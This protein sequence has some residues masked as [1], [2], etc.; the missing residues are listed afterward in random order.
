MPCDKSLSGS[1]ISSLSGRFIGTGILI[2]ESP[3]Q[4]FKLTGIRNH[5]AVCTRALYGVVRLD[6]PP[7]RLRRQCRPKKEYSERK[8]RCQYQLAITTCPLHLMWG[9]RQPTARQL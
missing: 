4:R 6:F 5:G 8:P 3:E 9:Q 2:Q 7:T 1:I